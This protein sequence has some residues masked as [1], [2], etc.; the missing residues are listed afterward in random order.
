MPVLSQTESFDGTADHM[1]EKIRSVQ[2]DAKR[3]IENIFLFVD[4]IR[5]N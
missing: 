3:L 2:F 1:L 5:S 4:P